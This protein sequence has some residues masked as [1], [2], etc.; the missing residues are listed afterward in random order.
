MT[1]YC[2]AFLDIT[3]SINISYFTWSRL[4]ISKADLCL[5]E[6]E[7]FDTVQK[8]IHRNQ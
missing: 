6:T 2:F 5:I 4:E 7:Q 1:G 8:K 3:D